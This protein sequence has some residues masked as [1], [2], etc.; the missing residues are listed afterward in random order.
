MDSTRAFACSYALLSVDV[1]Y[2]LHVMGQPWVFTPFAF[3]TTL[4][5][6]TWLCAAQ[7]TIPAEKQALLDLYSAT[8]GP[9]WR[10][11]WATALDPCVDGWAGLGCQQF[12]SDWRFVS[13]MCLDFCTSLTVFIVFGMPSVVNLTLNYFGLSGTDLPASLSA[14][15]HLQ[16]VV[17][18]VHVHVIT[19]LFTAARP[20][21]TGFVLQ[22]PACGPVS[23]CHLLHPQSHLLVSLSIEHERHYPRGHREFDTA[24][25]RTACS[26]ET[27]SY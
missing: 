11:H 17:V 26:R 22:H 2:S 12:G 9:H 19:A 1:R 25:V 16:F 18:L 13:R 27:S 21:E 10:Y 20:Q 8:N 24:N 6:C 5:A 15:T 4:F 7:V 23:G 14:L 3:V